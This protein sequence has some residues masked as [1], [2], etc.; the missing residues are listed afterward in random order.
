MIKAEGLV[1]TLDLTLA[2]I[3]A[4]LFLMWCWWIDNG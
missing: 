2:I 4:I 3:L 1:M